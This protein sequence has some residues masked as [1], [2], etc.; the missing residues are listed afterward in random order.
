STGAMLQVQ[1][2]RENQL[3][4][5]RDMLKSRALLERVVDRMGPATIL[6]GQSKTD[7]IGVAGIVSTLTD[8]ASSWSSTIKSHVSLSNVTPRELAIDKLSK[9]IGVSLAKNSSVITIT[10]TAKSSPLAQEILQAFLDAYREQHLAA[11]RTD[12]SLD[13]FDVQSKQIKHELD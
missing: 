3:N 10:C 1:E 13:F 2:S 7:Q 9:S 12:G 4:S 11:N 6:K 8:N 5:A